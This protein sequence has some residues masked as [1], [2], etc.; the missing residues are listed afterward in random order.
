MC[1]DRVGAQWRLHHL[2]RDVVQ[3]KILP[4]AAGYNAALGEFILK[5]DDLRADASPAA[6]LMEFLES[7][8]EA[9]ANLAGWDRSQLE[10]GA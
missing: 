2:A 7:T 5:Y 6:A 10:R 1:P 9:A 4:A 3:A 8:Y